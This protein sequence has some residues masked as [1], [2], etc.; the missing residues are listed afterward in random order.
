MKSL[1]MGRFSHWNEG[2]VMDF[3]EKYFRWYN[4][5]HYHSRIGYV[6]PEQMHQ[7]LAAGIIAERKRAW[8]EKQ[9]L[10]KMYWSAN[11]TTGSG[12]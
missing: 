7:D 1:Y 4:T 11:Q 6:T 12:L 9:K 10:R 2:V 3:F 8:G 5:E